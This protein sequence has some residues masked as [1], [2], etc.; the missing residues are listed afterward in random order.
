[1][2]TSFLTNGV[3]YYN[4]N[5]IICLFFEKITFSFLG[6][7]KTVLGFYRVVKTVILTARRD[8]MFHRSNAVSITFD[9]KQRTKCLY[10]W[11]HL[12]LL[13]CGER[14]GSKIFLILRIKEKTCVPFIIHD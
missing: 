2:R 13:L 8:L 1:M 5:F 7:F 6:F 12:S 3:L 10:T 11:F 4:N 14:S 9:G